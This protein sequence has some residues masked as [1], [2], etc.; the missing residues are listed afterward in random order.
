M[1]KDE[2]KIT[3]NTKKHKKNNRV[4]KNKEAQEKYTHQLQKTKETK[5]LQKKIAL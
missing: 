3:I 5:K 4:E 2:K 1:K